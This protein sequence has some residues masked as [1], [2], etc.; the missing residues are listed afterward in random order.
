MRRGEDLYIPSSLSPG[1]LHILA[2]HS[3][4]DACLHL[5]AS[6]PPLH[7]SRGHSSQYALCQWHQAFAQASPSNRS[8]L[9]GSLLVSPAVTHTEQHGAARACLSDGKTLCHSFL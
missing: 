4:Q 7:T 8:T 3:S 9:P 6:V 1:S 2:L 5:L